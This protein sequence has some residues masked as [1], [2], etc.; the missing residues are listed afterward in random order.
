MDVTKTPMEIVGEAAEALVSGDRERLRSLLA[1]DCTY[2][3]NTLFLQTPQFEG[4]DEV[5]DV[6]FALRR[7]FPDLQMT[8]LDVFSA[9]EKVAVEGVFSGTHSGEIVLPRITIA[10]TN[11]RVVFP[12]CQIFTV[13]HGRILQGVMY[14]DAA[15]VAAQETFT[16]SV[17]AIPV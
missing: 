11:E 3:D 14:Y 7:A 5:L 10:A 4:A 6:L 16:Y 9:G 13:K 2:S 15:T 12:Y 17:S 1:P 8:V